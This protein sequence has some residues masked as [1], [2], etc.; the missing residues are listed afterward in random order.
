[1]KVVGMKV[2]ERGSHT[3]RV[4]KQ[5]VWGDN[6]SARN[7]SEEYRKN[8]D[9]IFKKDVDKSSENGNIKERSNEEIER[10]ERNAKIRAQYPF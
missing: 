2:G 4:G 8:Y 7:V 1:M 6:G 5:A 3:D 9:K 10:L